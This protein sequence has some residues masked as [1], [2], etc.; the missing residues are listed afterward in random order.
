[1]KL[2]KRTLSL[3]LALVMIATVASFSVSANSGLKS[4]PEIN[5]VYAANPDEMAYTEEMGGWCTYYFYM[6]EEWKNS[7]NDYYDGSADSYC[8][9]I[10][11]WEGPFDADDYANGWPGFA[12]LESDVDNVY[13]AQVPW[14]VSTILWNNGVNGGNIPGAPE[15]EMARQTDD[16]VSTWYDPGQDTYGF[17]PEG[18]ASFDGMIYVVDPNAEAG[19]TE[20]S[21]AKTSPGEWFYYYGNGQ[22]GPYASLE[23]AT[24]KNAV[25]SNGAFP[26][27]GIQ[28]SKS[29]DSMAVGETATLT[30]DTAAEVAVTAGADKVTINKTSVAAGG[31]VI[32]TGKAV[33]TATITFTYLNSSGEAATKNVDITVNADKLMKTSASL[34]AGETTSI[35]TIIGTAKSYKSSNTKVATVDNKGKV[36]ALKKGT[37]T[38]T[39]TTKS[40][41]KLSFKATVTSNPKAKVKAT[42]VKVKKN[43]VVFNVTG[44][45][46]VTA[47]SSNK[48]VATVSVTAISGGKCKVK[49]KGVKKGN[50]KITV[51]VN[52]TAVKVTQKVKVK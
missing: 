35:R 23:E 41:Q 20:V 46:T 34:K 27:Y 4:M 3:V 6:P 40:G 48:K 25:Y 5:A 14:Y 39:V 10:Y 18:V 8:A 44:A 43:A 19:S 28:I 24:A 52:G 2:F 32:V 38:I 37:A 36:T 26:K 7:Y 17:Y 9:G 42:T 13:A 21:I 47:K 31:S 11:W 33:G 29:T 50:A 45:A 51:K 12:V 16:I 49:V 15:L 30:V 22:Y 1:M